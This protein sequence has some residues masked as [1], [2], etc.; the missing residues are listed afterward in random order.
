M[1]ETDRL[2]EEWAAHL[3]QMDWVWVPTEFNRQT[4]A[5]SGVPSERI[6]VV[7][8]ALDTARY[9]LEAGTQ[10]PAEAQTDGRFLFVSVFDWTLH[11]GWDVLLRT[12]GTELSGA[13]AWAGAGFDG[14]PMGTTPASRLTFVCPPDCQTKALD[15]CGTRPGYRAICV[16]PTP[17]AQVIWLPGDSF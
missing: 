3:R 11:K 4:F 12:F 17:G 14:W 5:E 6:L 9:T 7:P 8:G 13:M 15:W 16:P 1:F 2:P 10:G